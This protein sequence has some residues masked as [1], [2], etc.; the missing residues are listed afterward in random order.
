MRAKQYLGYTKANLKRATCAIAVPGT[1]TAESADTIYV[2]QSSG[3][4][5]RRGFPRRSNR[6]G[7]TS[8]GGA[9]ASNWGSAGTNPRSANGVPLVRK[10][11]PRNGTT[12][13]REAKRYTGLR[14][15]D[16]RHVYA[17]LASDAGAP[18]AKMQ[19]ALRHAN[20][21]MTRRYERRKARSR[22]WSG[23]R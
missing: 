9:L 14:I 23:A 16:L 6:D 20:P 4:G 8:T 7:C 19:A 10:V 18:T 17:Q 21:A 5:S 1:K 3:R 12:V 2:G 11:K 13:E 22:S 15:Y